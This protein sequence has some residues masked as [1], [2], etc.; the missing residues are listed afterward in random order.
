MLEQNNYLHNIQLTRLENTI[1]F[2]KTH[3]NILRDENLELSFKLAKCG[4]EIKQ[5]K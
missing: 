1:S 5:V 3:Y 2:V 4:T